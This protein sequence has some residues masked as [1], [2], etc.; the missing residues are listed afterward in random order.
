MRKAVLVMLL[1]L[2]S[3]SAAAAWVEVGGS[4][5]FTAYVDPSS[6][7]R[8][9]N[10]VKMW[11][12]HDFKTAQVSQSTGERYRSAKVE[13]EHD[14]RDERWRILYFTWHSGNLGEGIVV[15]INP[16]PQGWV[17]VSPGSAAETQWKFA[18]GKQ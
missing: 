8:A 4:E 10:R 1:A 12:L 15:F 18:C 3:S 5:G 11:Y 17:P 13:S 16:N 7:R 9:G 14:C 2:V 6:I